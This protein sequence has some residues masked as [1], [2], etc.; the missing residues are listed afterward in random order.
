MTLTPITDPPRFP[1]VFGRYI[2]EKSLSRG[3]MGEVVLAILKGV[4]QYCTI[5]TI[6]GDLNQ[7][8]EF[9]GR[10]A[11][12]AKIMIRMQHPNIIRVFDAGKVANDYYIAMEYV[13]GRDLGD[14]LDRAYERGEPMPPQIGI[15]ISELLLEGLSCVHELTDESG[16]PMGLVHRDI[17]PQNVLIGFDGAVKL[18]DFG[19]ARSL[20]LPGH[21]QG[22]LAI[23]KYGY[24]SPEQARHEPLDGRADLYSMGAML[25]EV[26]TGDRLVDEQDQKTLWQRVLNPEHRSVREVLPGLPAEIEELVMTA[27]QTKPE[28]RFESARAMKRFLK[29][30]R[31]QAATPAQVTRYL[32][33]LYPKVD[34]RRPKPPRFEHLAGNSETTNIVG[35]RAAVLSVFG[36]GELAI[37]WADKAITDDV[38]KPS[39]KALPPAS[40]SLWD[41]AAKAGRRKSQPIEEVQTEDLPH[42]LESAHTEI[43]T[44]P[45]HQLEKPAAEPQILQL[46]PKLTLADDNRPTELTKSP[47]HFQ[48]PGDAVD[49]DDASASAA[50][51]KA[52]PG[53]TTLSDTTGPVAPPEV[54]EIHRA[55]VP[56]V[57]HG[58]R[59]KPRLPRPSDGQG[60]LRTGQGPRYWMWLVFVL[61]T[62]VAVG[63]LLAS[64]L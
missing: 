25:F 3:G 55:T 58:A 51:S 22:A 34:T 43:M 60:G 62:L 61:G 2:L 64:L 41:E 7:E 52:W 33:Y 11:D 49:P 50:S 16:R 63:A 23:G 54:P 46:P 1:K 17:S 4:N 39:P 30:M 28:D 57:T 32:Q 27:V 48:S 44:S 19:L 21:T 40:G 59:S 24:M 8:R 47:L 6:R 31:T 10:F 45:L 13:H 5:K 26:F 12:E 18:I 38:S 14:V 42:T 15:Y 56:T 20:V 37:A 53:T 9:I 29:G 36:R 35:S